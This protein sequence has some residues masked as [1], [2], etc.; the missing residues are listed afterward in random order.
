MRNQSVPDSKHFPQ[1]FKEPVN[2]L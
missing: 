1:R 2:D